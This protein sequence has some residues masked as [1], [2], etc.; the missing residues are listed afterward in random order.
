[1]FVRGELLSS[2]VFDARY[3]NTCW[4][5]IATDDCVK[6]GGT[7]EAKDGKITATSTFVSK[8][9]EAADLRKQTQAENIGWYAGISAD[10]FG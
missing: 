1:M 4:S 5:L 9:G 7:Y 2:R 3:S 8:T 10:M 6:I